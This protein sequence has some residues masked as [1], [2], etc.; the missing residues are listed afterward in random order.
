MHLYA[1][2]PDAIA[3]ARA[4][5][6]LGQQDVRPHAP[7]G[8]AASRGRTHSG[9]PLR[10]VHSARESLPRLR[11]HRGRASSAISPRCGSIIRTGTNSPRPPLRRTPGGVHAYSHVNTFS[12]AAMAYAVTGDETVSPTSSATPTISCRTRQCYATG[13]FGPVERIMPANG[14]LGKALELPA[15]TPARRRAARG[16]AFKLARYLTQFTGEA[17]YGDWIERLLYNGIGAAPRDQGPG[18]HFYYADY[19]VGGGRED[20]CAAAFTPAAPAP[21]AR[22][23]PTIPT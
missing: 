12:S 1:G 16:P 20:L 17:R 22:P 7:A 13:G 23:W 10:M 3:A 6:G 21:T 9:R 14:N 5:H 4:G 19:R 15:R 18:R 2:H 11:A 8:R